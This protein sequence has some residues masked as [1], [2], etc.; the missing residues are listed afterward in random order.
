MLNNRAKQDI[1]TDNPLHF[2]K[3]TEQKTSKRGGG[4]C[5]VLWY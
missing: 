4:L 3:A 1:E 5:A 2:K